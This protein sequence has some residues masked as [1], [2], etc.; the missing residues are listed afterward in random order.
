MNRK[1]NSKILNMN[2]ILKTIIFLAAL[3]AAFYAGMKF[4]AYVYDDLCLD[5]GGGK[6]PG[7]YP[8]CVMERKTDQ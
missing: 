5:L 1:L 2:K 3:M 6:Q 4:Q 8:I 7:D